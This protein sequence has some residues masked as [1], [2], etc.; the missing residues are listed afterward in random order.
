VSE[1]LIS[2]GLHILWDPSYYLLLMGG[3]FYFMNIDFVVEGR[4]EYWY[5]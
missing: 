4:G 5:W 1:R 3:P 2:I